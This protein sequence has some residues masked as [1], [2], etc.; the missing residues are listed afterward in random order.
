[1]ET[2]RVFFDIAL[3]LSEALIIY[4]YGNALFEKRFKSGVTISGIILLHAVLL[5]FYQLR[6][7]VLNSVLL[8]MVFMTVFTLLFKCKLWVAAFNSIF[9][10]GIMAASEWFI[11]FINTIFLK[12]FNAY[13]YNNNIEV[14]EIVLSKLIYYIILLSIIRLFRRRTRYTVQK[15]M[16]LWLMILPVSSTFALFIFRYISI[17]NKL[18]DFSLILFSLISIFLLICDIIVFI[19]YDYSAQN[20]AKLYALQAAKQKE[21]TDKMYFDILEKNNNDL[22]MMKHDIKNHLEQIDSLSD[23]DE[24]HQYISSLHGAL[25]KYSSLGHSGNRNLDIIISK[26]TALCSTKN[27]KIEFSIKMANL[28]SLE[29]A[30][31]SAIMNNLLDNALEAAEKSEHKEITVDIFSR[32]LFEVICI[33][34]SCDIAPVQAKRKLI[35]LKEDKELHGLGISSVQKALKKYDGVYEWEYDEENHMFKSTVAIPYSN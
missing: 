14:L 31:L 8:I 7:P 17:E 24:V 1:M 26:Y 15:S 18:T 20:T 35:S 10:L 13:Q 4:Y 9:L 2:F 33:R 28:S 34:N 25:N 21:E 5:G 30:D 32:N 22:R 6:S 3:Y 27:I 16:F 11:L 19:L 12:D 29:P 23:S